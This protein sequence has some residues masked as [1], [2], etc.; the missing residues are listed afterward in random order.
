MGRVYVSIG[1]NVNK[2]ANVGSAL[3]VLRTTF[4][5]LIVSTV[6]ETEPVG[7]GGD[8]FYNLVVAFDT[9]ADPCEVAKTLRRIEADHGRVRRED[10]FAPRTLD[11]DLLLY[12]DVILDDNGL[13]LPREEI[14]RYAFVLCP[15][16][17]VAGDMPHP[18][19][20][21]P[22]KELWADMREANGE[23]LRAVVPNDQR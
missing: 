14:I 16:A 17:E 7:F 21:R 4:G 8:D 18:A 10:R 9:D 6:Y 1:S 12:D 3:A 11:L 19:L 23:T 2:Q 5:E 20:G 15:L 22:L 13:Q